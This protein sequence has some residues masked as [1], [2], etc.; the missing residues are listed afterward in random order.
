MNTDN[1]GRRSQRGLEEHFSE[2][3]E[4]CFSYI[5]DNFELDQS[6]SAEFMPNKIDNDEV[7]T[8]LSPHIQNEQILPPG[9]P[10]V[11]SPASPISSPSSPNRG[12]TG[13]DSPQTPLPK[14]DQVDFDLSTPLT[15]IDTSRRTS[16]TCSFIDR[17]TQATPSDGT[18]ESYQVFAD[19]DTKVCRN[20]H[21]NFQAIR[22]T[23]KP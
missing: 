12:S 1:D 8:L 7:N 11:L 9:T 3:I 17:G 21:S 18:H 22:N 20:L 19:S 15:P 10:I 13:W 5:E 6:F 4:G 23:G 16:K 14:S 2:F